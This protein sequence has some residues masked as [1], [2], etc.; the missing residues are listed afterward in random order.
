ME[1]KT[2]TPRTDSYLILPERGIPI[3]PTSFARQLERE[4]AEKTNEASNWH[5]HYRDEAS[6]AQKCKQ[7]FIEQEKEVARLRELLGMAI[8]YT[9]NALF[10][11]R[12]YD[13]KI[14]WNEIDKLWD[15]VRDLEKE[16]LAPAPNEPCKHETKNLMLL[17]SHWHWCNRCGAAQRL[18]DGKPFGN[19]QVPDKDAT[20]PEEPS[21]P[22]QG[23]P[24]PNE[25]A[26]SESVWGT[27]WPDWESR[28]KAMKMACEKLEEEVARL[29][30][31]LKDH[32]TFLRKNGFDRQADDL[33]RFA[34]APEEPETSAH[35]DKC[36][37][38]VTL[39]LKR[40]YQSMPKHLQKKV[41]LHD[42]KL[43]C[44]AYNGDQP[45][46]DNQLVADKCEKFR[47][48]PEETHEGFSKI[49][50]TEP[51][52]ATEP[53]WRELGKDE[54]ICEGDEWGEESRWYPVGGW[55]VGKT[56]SQ[57]IRNFRTRRLKQ[58]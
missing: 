15:G 16:T 29:R 55:A 28:A 38:N 7:A 52:S 30:G 2:P 50:S 53:E 45:P 8:G 4:L 35:I 18:V 33:M 49:E 17:G 5:Q 32:A 9:K 41:S 23:L 31:L 22:E 14:Q 48:R 34:P 39:D 43:I 56:S 20:A 13:N 54:V 44:D 51:T 24:T 57:F 19:W 21:Y 42:L 40:L 11:A 27:Y 36:I 46:V 1:N 58:P 6:K 37:G 3:V 12:T 47:H 10:F 26:L 25:V